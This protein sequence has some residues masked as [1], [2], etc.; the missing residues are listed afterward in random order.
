MKVHY[1]LFFVWLLVFA[2]WLVRQFQ[3]SNSK[4]D[5]SNPNRD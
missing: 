2:F 5:E 1:I 4:Y 3:S